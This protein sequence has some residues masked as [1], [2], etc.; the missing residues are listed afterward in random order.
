MSNLFHGK[1]LVHPFT[2]LVLQQTKMMLYTQDGYNTYLTAQKDYWFIFVPISP[3]QSDCC[4]NCPL[5]YLY[6]PPIGLCCFHFLPVLFL[7]S[8]KLI[9][10][11][12]CSIQFSSIL[13][14][15]K[16]RIYCTVPE[17]QIDNKTK[18]F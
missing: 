6:S 7:K 1:I 3:N 4:K 17:L 10:E 15:A 13:A 8:K 12:A 9:S 2:K 5:W 11:A 18:T 14:F 16:Y